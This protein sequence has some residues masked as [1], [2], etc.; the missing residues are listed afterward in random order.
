MTD[1]FFDLSTYY[2]VSRTHEVHFNNLIGY[3]DGAFKD[4]GQPR[5]TAPLKFDSSHSLSGNIPASLIHSTINYQ[6]LRCCLY[7]TTLRNAIF[8]IILNYVRMSDYG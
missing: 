6:Q 3:G 2:S 4:M 7:L 8:D 1:I 5:K